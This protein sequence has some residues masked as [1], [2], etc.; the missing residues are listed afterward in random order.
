MSGHPLDLCECGDYRRDHEGGEGRCL[1]LDHEIPCGRFDL[2]GAH[3][4]GEVG[5]EKGETLMREVAQ[6]EEGN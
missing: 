6:E 3:G 1:R 2:F 4:G 5:E